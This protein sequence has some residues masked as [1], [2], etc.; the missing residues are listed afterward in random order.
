MY[1]FTVESIIICL[2]ISKGHM[3][4]F[5]ISKCDV[6]VPWKPEN[7][8]PSCKNTV[9]SQW[10]LVFDTVKDFSYFMYKNMSMNMF[11]NAF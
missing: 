7:Q 2:V 9:L 6:M 10:P 8:F 11:K 4:G 5:K 3:I 1:L